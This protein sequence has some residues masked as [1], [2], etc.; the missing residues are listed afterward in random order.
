MKLKF[1]L[2][3]L[4]C[5]GLFKL[6]TAQ[7]PT[8][9][10]TLSTQAD[11]D[12]F[13]TDYPGCTMIPAGVDVT[14]QDDNNGIDN[15]TNLNGL[16][17]LTSIG[18]DLS[19]IDNAVLTN[20]D[21]LSQLTSIGVFFFISENAVLTN[22]DGLSQLTSI[23][24]SFFIYRSDALTNLDGLSQLATIGGFL[25]MRENTA[26]T[27]LDGLSQLTSIGGNLFMRTNAALTNVDGLNQLTSVGGFLAISQNN[28]LTNVDGLSQLT[29]IGE[30]LG[31]NNNNV[32]TNIDG[33]SQ[34]TSVGGGI[35]VEDNLA[36]TNVDGLSQVTSIPDGL[37]INDNAALTNVN[38]LSQV[39]SVGG[40]LRIND[41]A[42]LT[43]VDGLG[44][45]TSVGGDLEV[46]NN[47]SLNQ[48]CAFCPLFA[49]DALDA[50]VI[51]GT[52]TI[53]NNLTDCNSEAEI[54]ACSPCGLAPVPTLGQ[55]GLILL[56]LLLLNI[57]VLSIY[58]SRYQV[59]GVSGAYFSSMT[60]GITTVLT[61]RKAFL[62]QYVFAAV[63]IVILFA[64]SSLF[65]GYGL[66]PFD[67]PGSILAAG[68][69]AFCMRTLEL[70]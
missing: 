37:R 23:G 49:A 47:A 8:S 34:L 10:I 22:V 19:I 24:G 41:N 21:G 20:I 56:A 4:L 46:Q 68:L 52:I 5:C 32:L 29:S 53:Q 6:S 50:T 57:G 61:D 11:I 13:S 3:L 14:I 33:L 67:V 38:G 27:N 59:A 16:S 36:L 64:I 28:A 60:M 15:I 9:S 48:C 40:S 31:I 35:Y 62:K 42:A 30:Q 17:Q 2:L 25:F 55:W 7:C 66:M 1:I 63:F 51:D 54:N 26:L 69:L 58:Q 44:Q 43:N 39:T 45:V 65:F 12:N 70:R 18:E